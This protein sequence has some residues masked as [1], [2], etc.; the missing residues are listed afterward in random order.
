MTISPHPSERIV[1]NALRPD[2]NDIVV[3]R[4]RNRARSCAAAAR[5]PIALIARSL[6][7]VFPRR[8]SDEDPVQLA[9]RPL[10]GEPLCIMLSMLASAE[11]VQLRVGVRAE[12]LTALAKEAAHQDAVIGIRFVEPAASKLIA[13]G[14]QSK[15]LSV[16]GKTSNWGPMRGLVPVD[17][18]LSKLA[19]RGRDRIAQSSAAVKQM[20]REEQRGTPGTFSGVQNEHGARMQIVAAPLILSTCAFAAQYP[21]LP[22]AAKPD[23]L[24]FQDEIMPD[25]TFRAHRRAKSWTF[26]YAAGAAPYR[27]LKVVAYQDRDASNALRG[28]PCR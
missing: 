7:D 19:T 4:R 23:V 17:Q 15:N 25:I 14:Y 20:L 24:G 13:S 8:G 5:H 2:A 10:C 12:H 16:K 22:I 26:T 9:F 28:A 11:E 3:Q 1:S 21:H 18:A 27:P 6:S